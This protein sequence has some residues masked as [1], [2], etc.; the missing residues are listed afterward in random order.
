MQH[1][2]YQ[3]TT[4]GGG[5]YRPVSQEVIV[6]RIKQYAEKHHSRTLEDLLPCHRQQFIYVLAEIIGFSQQ[7]CADIF[8]K[9]KS[10]VS[11]DISDAR[12]FYARFK[13]YRDE[14]E[15]KYRY[16]LYNAKYLR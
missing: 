4:A 13:N 10:V 5:G 6:L 16:L 1:T 11:R 8:Q 3:H 15:R 12:F 14:I 7:Q 9:N 2:E